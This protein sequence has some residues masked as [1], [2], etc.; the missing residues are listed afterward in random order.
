MLGYRVLAIPSKVVEKVRAT[1][2]APG[3]GH[4]SYTETATG[5]GPCRHC[6]RTFRVGEDRRT[7]FTYDPFFGIED[8]PLPGPVFIHADGCERYPEHGAYP[9][10]ML[11]HSAIFNAYGKGQKLVARIVVHPNDGHEAKLID[12]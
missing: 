2:R 11:E 4:P 6:L 9:K 10:D 1:G 8:I 7:L 5:Y 12:L 3:Y